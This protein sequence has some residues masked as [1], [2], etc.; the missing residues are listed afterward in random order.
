[1]APIPEPLG[2]LAVLAQETSGVLAE[3]TA[4]PAQWIRAVLLLLVGLPLTWTVSTWLRNQVS[5]ASTP[6][7]GLVVGKLFWYGGLGAIVVTVLLELGFNLSPLLGAAGILGIALGFASQTSVSNV[8]SGFFLMAEEAFVVG[9][10]I[11]VG[12]TTGTVLSIDMMSV[13]L[14]TFDNRFIRIPNE[15]LVK[16]EVTTVTRFPIRRVDVRVGVAYKE[17]LA[18]VRRVLLEVAESDPRALMEPTPV[19]IFQGFGESSLDLL[20]GV[21]TTRE[22]WIDLKNSIH[23]GIKARFDAE[24][25]EIPF[26]H[27]TLYTG[28]ATDPFPIRTRSVDPGEAA[29][30]GTPGRDTEGTAG[31]PPGA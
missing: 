30:D 8:I 13:K 31:P 17:D 14:R 11:T 4:D 24:G 28:S 27:R 18:R 22:N 5:G 12:S 20:F 19:I 16:S 23:D 1:M 7:R 3:V 26:P 15:Q 6:Q 10:I 9:D 2:L 21:W 25:I 29:A